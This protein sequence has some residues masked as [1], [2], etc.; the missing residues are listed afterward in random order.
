MTVYNTKPII[1]SK[2]DE[3]KIF[4]TNLKYG[5]FGV[6]SGI[7]FMYLGNLFASEVDCYSREYDLFIPM[8]FMGFGGLEVLMGAAFPFLMKAQAKIY[9]LS[10]YKECI[11]GRGIVSSQGSLKGEALNFEEKAENFSSVSTDKSIVII[12]LRDGRRIKCPA[13][14]AEEIALVI[15]NLY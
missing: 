10:V 11:I 8:L 14:N 4:N 2:R 7:F 9:H 1:T 15:R 3:N 13:D 5:I 12:N 6:I